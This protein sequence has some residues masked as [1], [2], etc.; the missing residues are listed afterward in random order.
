MK[1]HSD[2]VKVTGPLIDGSY[3]ITFSVG[4]YE[5]KKVAELMMIPQQTMIQL[6][7]NYDKKQ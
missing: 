6:D 1:I 3:N 5:Q 4:E 7:I 2:K